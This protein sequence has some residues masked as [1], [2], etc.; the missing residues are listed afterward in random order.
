MTLFGNSSSEK[1][2]EPFHQNFESPA[3]QAPLWL[4]LSHNSDS[5]E[6]ELSHIQ[7]A[8]EDP[9]RR[10]TNRDLKKNK[11]TFC[12]KYPHFHF[13]FISEKS[14]RERGFRKGFASGNTKLG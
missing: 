4:W 11:R 14:V 6:T 2:E 5:L 1:C 9:Q 7:T 12:N 8:V 3:A 10:M 13:K